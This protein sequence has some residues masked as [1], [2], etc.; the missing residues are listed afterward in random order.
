M[1]AAG[2]SP[3]MR[4][5]ATEPQLYQPRQ[6]TSASLFTE[7]LA[8]LDNR[9]PYENWFPKPRGRHSW[10]AESRITESPHDEEFLTAAHN[11]RRGTQHFQSLSHRQDSRARTHGVLQNIFE[12]MRGAAPRSGVARDIVSRKNEPSS[13]PPILVN[14]ILHRLRVVPTLFQKIRSEVI[15]IRRSSI[16]GLPSAAAA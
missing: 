15:K 2:F 7:F 3:S 9:E 13:S 5:T 14:Q 10:S 16:E 11:E 4:T 8:I 6:R 12:E 1:A